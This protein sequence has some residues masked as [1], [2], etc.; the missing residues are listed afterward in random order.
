M[1]N[2][3]GKIVLITGGGSGIGKIMTKLMLEREAKVWKWKASP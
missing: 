3:K 2:L 1:K